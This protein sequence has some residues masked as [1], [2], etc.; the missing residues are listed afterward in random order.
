[1][2]TPRKPIRII[3]PILLSFFL[4]SCGTLK[5]NF[6]KTKETEKTNSV[7][8]TVTETV[9]TS[10]VIERADTTAT[11]KADSLSVE[12]PTD[13]I[14]SGKTIITEDENTI[15]EIKTDPVTKKTT[16]KAKSKEKKIPVSFFRATVK[17]E[18]KKENKKEEKTT[19][20]KSESKTKTK[21]RTPGINTW[22]AWGYVIIIAGIILY[23][24]YRRWIYPIVRRRRDKD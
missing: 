23:Y 7:T 17:K 6:N 11:K 10:T 2:I 21:E 24:S 14:K 16:I 13:S 8:N 19:E 20:K 3:L 12:I 1:M 4:F 5:K 22:M 18:E 9:T 15:I